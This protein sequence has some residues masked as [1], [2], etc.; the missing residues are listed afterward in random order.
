MLVLL[1]LTTL[2]LPSVPPLP[3]IHFMNKN[4]CN[5]EIDA[6]VWLYLSLLL[7]DEGKATLSMNELAEATGLSVRQARYSLSKLEEAGL[8]KHTDKGR[9][10]LE[11]VT[12]FGRVDSPIKQARKAEKAPEIVKFPVKFPEELS[13]SAVVDSR[14]DGEKDAENLSDFSSLNHLRESNSKE[15]SNGSSTHLSSTPYNPP[16]SSLPRQPATK[17]A[18][19]KFFLNRREAQEVVNSV[20]KNEAVRAAA[21]EWVSMRYAKRG[22]HQLTEKAIRGAF[23]K[24]RNMGYNTE[25]K[26]VACFEQSI[27]HLWDGVFEIKE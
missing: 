3:F 20:T 9:G 2:H 23:Q 12:F 17:P 25:S 8:C 4:L 21:M 19:E 24:L 16:P 1:S 26:A 11:I 22:N 7:V 18:S 15:H 27:E 6:K 13:G 10:G 14:A 5:N